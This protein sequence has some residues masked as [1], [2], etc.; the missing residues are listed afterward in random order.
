MLAWETTKELGQRLGGYASRPE[1]KKLMGLEQP[2]LAM[3]Y[4]GE[5]YGQEALD[6]VVRRS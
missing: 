1:F 5:L 2:T 6:D 4:M 3:P